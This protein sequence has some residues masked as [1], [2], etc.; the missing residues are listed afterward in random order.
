MEK[1]YHL[2]YIDQNGHKQTKDF[3]V[4]V[5]AGLSYVQVQSK[6]YQLKH[7][8]NTEVVLSYSE[9]YK[10]QWGEEL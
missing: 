4:E 10:Y 8:G 7:T 1:C 6:G 3:C 9:N 2:T 5:C